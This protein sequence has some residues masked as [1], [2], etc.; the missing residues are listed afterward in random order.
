MTATPNSTFKSQK[1]PR[2]IAIG[3][4]HG[5]ALE[6]EALIRKLNLKSGD[7]IVFLGDYIDRGPDSKR[8]VD[9]ILD[10]A[11]RF[12]VIALKG[13]HEAMFIDFLETPD[14]PGAGLFILN[15]GSSTLASYS[16]G[17]AGE[18]AG[19][20]AG[21]FEIPKEHIDFFS[22]LRLWYET[23]TH[24]FVHAGVPLRSLASISVEDQEALLWS[25]QP[26]LSTERRWEK[27]IVHGH[28]PVDAPEIKANRINLD[29]GCVYDG[30]LTALDFSTMKFHWVEKGNKA[31]P[32]TY[33]RTPESS[34]VAMRFEGRLPVEAGRI[35]E[36]THRFETLN[37]NLFGILM[38]E[39]KASKSGPLLAVGD[40]IRGHIGSGPEKRIDFT[41][42]VA[43]TET[44][45]DTAVH[46]VSIERI[47][48]GNEGRAWIERPR[49]DGQKD[50]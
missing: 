48:N 12:E 21:S 11:S 15:G 40:R 27:V 43:R 28:T 36:K 10:L 42:V 33:L 32:V 6:L 35:G 13:N 30:F 39:L 45:G 20:N 49:N 29:T 37:Y 3:D 26:F 8:V 22:N 50:E 9:V 1:Q 7:R 19:R 24:F 47:T 31:Q 44:R 34:R 14:S 16:Q 4:I 38:R 18:N 23:E 41:G 17:Q 46:G 25:R 2:T 5:C